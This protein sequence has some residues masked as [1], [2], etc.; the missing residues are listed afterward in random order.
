MIYRR[1][2]L[3]LALLTL[4]AYSSA[5]TLSSAQLSFGGAGGSGTTNGTTSASRANTVNDAAAN[6]TAFVDV[7]MGIIKAYSTVSA[8]HSN[9]SGGNFA[10]ATGV[11][12]DDVTIDKVGKTGQTGTGRALFTVDGSVSSYGFSGFLSSSSTA[13]ANFSINDQGG[14]YWDRHRADE[15]FATNTPGG[16]L[17]R[18]ISVPFSFVYGTPFR[19]RFQLQ[20]ASSESHNQ[21]DGPSGAT[22][23]LAHTAYWGGFQSVMDSGGAE[24]T[25]FTVTSGSGTNWA[26]PVPEPGT[27][28]ALGLGGLALLRRRRSRAK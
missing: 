10:F 17:G 14:T 26:Q 9:S 12:Q 16:F 5:Q 20:A 27:I 4:A 28:V 18:E 11:W 6:R 8:N 7:T 23:D 13:T 15:G 19:M 22:T 25:D 3:P 2:A 21:G 1:A 24:V